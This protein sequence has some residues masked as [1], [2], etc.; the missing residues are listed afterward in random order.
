MPFYIV[1]DHPRD[2]KLDAIVIQ[3]KAAGLSSLFGGPRAGEVTVSAAR[4]SGF[5]YEIRMTCPVWKKGRRKVAEQLGKCYEQ[6]L[7]QA[8]EKTARQSCSL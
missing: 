2:R 1:Y 6:A 8:L 4:A 3:E 7:A 5:R